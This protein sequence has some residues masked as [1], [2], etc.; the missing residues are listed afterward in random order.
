MSIDANTVI[1][2]SKV[3]KQFGYFIALRNISLNIKKNIIYGFIGEN[4]AGK[5][6][7]I[8]ILAGLLKPTTGLVNIN[9]LNYAQNANQ[10]KKKIGLLTDEQFLYEDLSIYENL[11]FY[12]KIHFNFDKDE[13]RTKIEK[14]TKML[15]LFDWIS[16]PIHNLSK[17]MKKKVN[18]I[19]T[20]IHNPSI[21]FLDEPFS[22]LDQIT[23][24][25]IMDYL[26]ELKNQKNLTIMIST[27][28]IEIAQQLCDELIIIKKG[29]IVKSLS[30]KE[31]ETNTILE[32]I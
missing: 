21:I 27:H 8:K 29:K 28:N 6:T 30:K 16:E 32:Y 23:V 14:Y 12:D 5:T 24:K 9:G 22:S 2:C 17:G 3:S 10:I 11:R 20:L 26:L 7:L 25:K 1:K 13:L 31:F 19:R 15:N 4:G 18:L